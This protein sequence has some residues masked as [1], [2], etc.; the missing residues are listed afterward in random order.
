MADRFHREGRTLQGRVALVTGSV[1]DGIGRSTALALANLGADVALNYGTGRAQEEVESNGKCVQAAIEEMGSRSVL[2][3][4]N[5]GDEQEVISLF[6]QI[7]KDLGSVDILVN[8]AGSVWLE[9]DFADI[10]AERWERTIAAELN[11]AFYCMREALPAMREKRWGRIINIVV[12][13]TSLNLLI[14]AQYGHVLDKYPHAFAV[15][16]AARKS[17][18]HTLAFAELKNKITINN[19]LPGIIEDIS[20]DE[21]IRDATTDPDT[22]VATRPSDVAR[23]I[24]FLC[25]EEGGVITDS[26]IVIPGNLYSRL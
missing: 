23:V 10:S 13:P 8:N 25:L 3:R 12:D 21:A 1:G 18:T 20:L 6:Q 24:A 17:L 5:T 22:R 2:I 7:R 4:A 15:G 9:Q 14:N 11:G 16:K 26:D 19:I